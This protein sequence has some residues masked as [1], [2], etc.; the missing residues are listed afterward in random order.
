MRE[1]HADGSDHLHAL[2]EFPKE[3]RVSTSTFD[4]AF[5]KHVNISTSPIRS[6]QRVIDYCLKDSPSGGSEYSM[7]RYSL[8]TCRCVIDLTL[9]DDDDS[10]ESIELIDLQ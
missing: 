10:T 2:L 5:G 6:A 4:D 7:A 8:N 3:V 1:K 9:D